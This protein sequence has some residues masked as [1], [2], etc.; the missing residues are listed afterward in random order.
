MTGSPECGT[1]LKNQSQTLEFDITCCRPTI[2]SCLE[3]KKM[4]ISWKYGDLSPARYP[5]R[6]DK[7][8]KKKKP[9]KRSHASQK[10]DVV[11]E[12]AEP[13]AKITKDAK[14]IHR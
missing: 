4:S 9:A 11:H 6:E 7:E 8:E 13:P 12:A 2:N 10:H 14:E 1:I 5:F 3:K